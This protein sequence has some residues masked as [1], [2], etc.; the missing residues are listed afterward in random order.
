MLVI[1]IVTADPPGRVFPAFKRVPFN[2][3]LQIVGSKEGY[4]TVDAS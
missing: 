1:G 4:C 2:R 3:P